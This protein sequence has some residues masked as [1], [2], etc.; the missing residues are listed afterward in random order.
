MNTTILGSESN[1]V[2]QLEDL[3]MEHKLI[4]RVG[5]AHNTS[6]SIEELKTKLDANDTEQE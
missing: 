4:E 5:K 6:K 3:I 2:G 1:Y